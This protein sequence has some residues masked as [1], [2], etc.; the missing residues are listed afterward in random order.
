MKKLLLILVLTVL[1]AGCAQDEP[2]QPETTPPITTPVVVAPGLYIPQSDMEQS[3]QGA[4]RAYAAKEPVLGLIPLDQELMVATAT[5][6]DLVRLRILS[7]TNGV[8]RCEAVLEVGASVTEGFQASARGVCYYSP[9]AHC[10]VILDNTLQEQGR[11]SLPQE[12]QAIPVITRDF[13]TAYYCTGDQIRALSLDTG[14]S[15]LLKQHSCQWQSLMGLAANEGILVCNMTVNNKQQ[16]SFV[17]TVDGQTLGADPSLLTFSGQGENYFLQR[18]DGIVME[19]LHGSFQGEARVFTLPEESRAFHYPQGGHSIVSVTFGDTAARLEAYDLNSGNLY[20]ALDLAG[21]ETAHSFA[22]DGETLWFAAWQGDQEVICQWNTLASPAQGQQSYTT[23]RFTAQAPDRDALSACQQKANEMGQRYGVKI[24]V[25]PQ[26][27][28]QPDSY[29]LTT[30]HQVRALEQGLIQL[31]TALSRFPEDFFRRMAEDTTSKVLEI[32]LVRQIS[33]DQQ[34]LQYWLQA[35]AFIAIALGDDVEQ[36][37]YHEACHVLDTFLYSNTRDLDVWNKQN[38]KGFE[39]DYSYDLYETH[40]RKYLEGENRAFIDAYSRTYPKEDRALILEY[41]MMPGNEA[42]FESK[43][44]Q[45]K[46]HLLCFSIR[47]AYNWKRDSRTFPWE[48]Y[49]EEPLAYTKKK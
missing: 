37:F 9:V 10:L 43:T 36:L 11:V 41:A 38:P 30:E 21:V 19:Y 44:M 8:V 42:Y 25:D 47:D 39:Y 48:Q 17:S 5:D 46:L 45:K 49:L 6:D 27:V 14:V 13:S 29:V 35:D 15:R 18:R 1:L 32:S 4:L 28:K 40:D 24:T 31:E 12:L 22:A 34:G 7:G 23:Q 33:D 16:V 20:S 26:L 3:T 2:A